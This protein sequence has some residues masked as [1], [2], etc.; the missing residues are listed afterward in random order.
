MLRIDDTFTHL[1]IALL[2]PRGR[3]DLEQNF[4]FFALQGGQAYVKGRKRKKQTKY[5]KLAEN[6]WFFNLRSNQYTKMTK[7]EAL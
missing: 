1:F 2:Q 7:G 6:P 5:N 3:T 4:S